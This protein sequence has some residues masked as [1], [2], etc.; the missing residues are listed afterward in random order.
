MYVIIEQYNR[1]D[2]KANIFGLTS[3]HKLVQHGHTHTSHC[4]TLYYFTV[5]LYIR[6]YLQKK[7]GR[8][9]EK[10]KKERTRKVRETER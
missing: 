3:L 10:I 8:K 5:L 1:T 2:L 7:E 9:E 6:E 4:S